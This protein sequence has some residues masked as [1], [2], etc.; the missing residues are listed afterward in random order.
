MLTVKTNEH[1]FPAEQLVRDSSTITG[2]RRF[3]FDKE[4][5]ADTE[6]L[7]TVSSVSAGELNHGPADLGIGIQ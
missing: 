5:D 2:W 4:A 7:N 3:G 1:Y 6:I